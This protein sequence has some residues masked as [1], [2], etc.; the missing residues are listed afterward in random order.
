MYHNAHVEIREQ[1]AGL[2]SLLS[3]GVVQGLNSDCR[4]NVPLLT[5]L[6]PIHAFP[7]ITFLF[8]SHSQGY[9]SVPS[10]PLLYNPCSSMDC[11]L[12]I[13]DLT[14]NVHI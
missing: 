14:A 4:L 1:L 12:G 6:L 8:I 11:S 13:I 9:L 5:K 3:T 7:S 10:S 2:S